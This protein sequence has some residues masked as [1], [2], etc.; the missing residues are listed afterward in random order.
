MGTLAQ[1]VIQG[2]QQ[3]A[4]ASG[5][6]VGDA[7][8]AYNLSVKTQQM[9]QDIEAQKTQNSIN[10]ATFAF[11]AINSLRNYSPDMQKVIAPRIGE[12]LQQ[13]YPNMDPNISTALEKDSDFRNKFIGT[14]YSLLS[15]QHID[16]DTAQGLEA[17][18]G[19]YDKAQ[20]AME[21]VGKQNAEVAAGQAR[22]QG[23]EDRITS[24]QQTQMQG[25][26]NRQLDPNKP[27]MMRINGADRILHLMDDAEA[28]KFKT[29][30]AFLGQLN[31][32]I[33]RLE[34]GSQ[35]PGLNVQEKIEMESAAAEWGAVRDKFFNNISDVDLKAQVKQA[36]GMVQGLK[37][38]YTGQAL[39]AIEQV[40]STALPSQ[41]PIVQSFKQ[42]FINKHGIGRNGVAAKTTPQPNTIKV[43]NVDM[44]PEQAKQFYDEHPQFPRPKG[45]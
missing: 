43:G 31:A 14:A 7:L 9:Q 42:E 16:S 21:Q 29:N 18:L 3:N 40:G 44:T 17:A 38:S 4:Q 28:G 8:Q 2:A 6:T 19:G 15:R 11:N 36:R 12:Q 34:T 1:D 30:K 24:Q 37:D 25:A 5:Q 32:E 33:S 39:N 13:M 41:S 20:A 27:I 23:F 26:L 22:S 10:K 45:I 35:S